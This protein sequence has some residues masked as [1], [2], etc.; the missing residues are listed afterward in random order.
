[1][2]NIRFLSKYK[3]ECILSPLFKFLE[4]GI[5]LFVPIVVQLI[6]DV[7]INGNGGKEYI[8]KM[9]GL[10]V[11]LGIVG[12]CFSITAQ[13]FAAKAATLFA[14][15]LRHELFLKIQK[16]SFNDLDEVG[17]ST[18]INRMTNDVNLA[19]NTVNM[20]LRL[21]LRSPFVVFG[22]MIMAFTVDI[23]GAIVFVIIIPVLL[24][25]IFYI[26]NYTTPLFKEVQKK[27]DSILLSIRENLVGVRTIR[28][29]G[30]EKEEADSFNKKNNEMFDLQI[31]VGKVNS[32]LNPLT[33]VIINIG[34]VLVIYVGGYRVNTGDLSQGDVFALMNYMSQ[35]LVE[36]IKLANLVI[37][38]IK[39]KSGL[40]RIQSVFDIKTGDIYGNE[41]G[42]E[43]ISFDK[44]GKN[45]RENKIIEFEN[46]CMKY[47][48]NAD[49]AL[50]D[51]SFSVNEGDIIGIIGGTGCG[52]T[53]IVNMILGF[54]KAYKGKVLLDGRDIKDYNLNSVRK[55][56]GV[57]PQKAL[58]FK[59]SIRDNIKWGKDNAT[60]EEIIKALKIS[61]A[62]EFVEKKEG[63]LDYY[64]EQ[65]GKNFSGGQ[66]QRL[67]IARGIINNPRI[68]ILDDSA[69]ALDFATEAK[70]RKAI[71]ENL[72]TTTIIISQRISSIKHADKILV[73]DEGKLEGV[74]TH[75]E[76]LKTSN[77]YQEI[78]KAQSN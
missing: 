43:L 38:L 77:E 48:E 57:V 65:G 12:L 67:T 13:F 35:I 33:Y 42:R 34:I 74:G 5:E 26:L 21:V 11:L 14:K 46:V 56:I 52:K 55:N 44:A 25:V 28:A 62:Y 63:M 22:A 68:L 58:L 70:L 36:A 75:E 64:S 30:I 31:K 37:L 73:L 16:L 49:D 78:Y 41:E 4:A 6:I 9:G 7:G 76:L 23:K 10:L 8:F 71:K 45:K 51:I 53:T 72:K 40:E 66:R 27:S 61:Q 47:S 17:N 15:D 29:F 54:Y 60:D 69:S 32:L 3:K 1:M 50:N 39:G 24:F 20:V 2:G 59:G 18:L 19:Q